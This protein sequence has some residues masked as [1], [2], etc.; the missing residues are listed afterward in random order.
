[1]KLVLKYIK[2]YLIPVFLVIVLLLGQAASE[3]ELPNLMSDIVNVGLQRGGLESVLPEKLGEGSAEFLDIFFDDE[4]S[5]IF[6]EAYTSTAD[7]FELTAPSLEA[8][9]V[10]SQTAA[11]ILR[12]FELGG[13]IDEPD[14]ALAEQAAGNAAD[15]ESAA[16]EQAGC[17]LTLQLYE[18]QGEDTSAIQRNYML[19]VG[20]QML[21]VSLLSVA[22]AIGV[23]FLSARISASVARNM[24]HDVFE[25]VESFSNAEFDRFSTA[26]LITR[27]T[28][29]VQQVQQ[30]IGMG[31]RMMVR[32]PIM[33][34]GGII[35]ALQKSSSM[36][37]I[38]ALAVVVLVAMQAIIFSIATP[39]FRIM[40]KLVDRLNLI[41]RESLTGMMVIRA[42]GNEKREEARFDGASRYLSDTQR[43]T[44]RT[45]SIMHPTT[46]IIMNL[47]GLLIVWVGAEAIAKS[48]LQVGDMMAFM[49][50]ANQVC[51]AFLM[52]AMIFIDIPRAA[53]AANRVREVLDTEPSI[54]DQKDLSEL[55]DVRGEIVFDKVCFRYPGAEKDV[56]HD[57][58]FTAHPGKTTAIIGSTGSG[59]STLINLVPRFY[60]VTSGKIEIDGIDIRDVPQK[61]LRDKI[62][63]VP[64]RG[65][66]FTGNIMTNVCYGLDDIDEQAAKEAIEVAQASE[67][68]FSND[69]GMAREIAQ[70]G[71]NV[72]GGQRQ[73]LAIARAI[74]KKPAIYIFDDSF[75]ALDFKTDIALRTALMRYT[76]DVTVL[77][78]AQRISTVMNADQIIVLDNGE[79]VGKGSHGELMKYCSEYREIAESQLS[80]E[81]LA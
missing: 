75:S 80:K 34:I 18:R 35:F 8:E 32:A 10:Y 77:I 70:G 72:S 51:D 48:T 11:V 16:A 21:A 14:A 36:S 65:I 67:F 54:K 17:K 22:A 44:N 31:M 74:V 9:N 41:S 46:T 55:G 1:M 38:I 49:Q 73:R 39:K 62:G 40:Q 57:I 4:E 45:M 68:V 23:G 5:G 24:R 25:K 3:L 15:T 71:G 52:I 28:N 33:G 13:N 7:G 2:P 50:Y 27:T 53:V 61:Q 30:L 58:S 60:D 20:I 47:M 26:S 6:F 66:L 81:E 42:F 69:E 29:D 37:W 76:E 12:Y 43:F 59:K 19:R 56:I 63:Y 78:V 64:Q 79:I